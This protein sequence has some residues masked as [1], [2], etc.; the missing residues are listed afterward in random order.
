[1]LFGGE[2]RQSGERKFNQTGIELASA[3]FFV[4]FQWG[5]DPIE[6]DYFNRGSFQ[7]AFSMKKEKKNYQLLQCSYAVC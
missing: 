1:M 6:S 3:F 2:N 5:P 4:G 7:V